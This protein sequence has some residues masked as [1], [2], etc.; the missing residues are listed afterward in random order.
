LEQRKQDLFLKKV[1]CIKPTK[2]DNFT[3]YPV[4][5][6]GE[7]INAVK[8]VL[9]LVFNGNRTI[10]SNGAKGKIYFQHT[11]WQYLIHTTK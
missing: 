10:K 8:K 9:L 11:L 5:Q 2:A 1:I 6:V 7:G 4:I 3:T